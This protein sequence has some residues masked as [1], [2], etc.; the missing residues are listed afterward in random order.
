ME[1][2]FDIKWSMLTLIWTSF[3]GELETEAPD[4]AASAHKS[5]SLL[6]SLARS[7][8]TLRTASDSVDDSILFV[9]PMS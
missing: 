3:G 6:Q 9:G 4:I 1:T 5:A 8:P 7:S 2:R